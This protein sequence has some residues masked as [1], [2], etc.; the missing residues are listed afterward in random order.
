MSFSLSPLAPS[1]LRHQGNTWRRCAKAVSLAL[2]KLY[3]LWGVSPHLFWGWEDISMCYL[4]H[5]TDFGGSPPCCGVNTTQM[6]IYFH[7]CNPSLKDSDGRNKHNDRKTPFILCMP[8]YMPEEKCLVTFEMPLKTLAKLFL[9]RP[10]KGFSLTWSFPSMVLA[11][12]HL[13]LLK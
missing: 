6:E 3:V 12:E 4:V 2:L 13:I 7:V 5:L 10:Y 8:I 1:L 11:A 9:E